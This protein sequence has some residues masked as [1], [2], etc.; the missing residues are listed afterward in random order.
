MFAKGETPMAISGPTTDHQEIRRWAKSKGA[1][2]V[3][4]LPSGIDSEPALLRLMLK[5][6]TK[7]R[8]V[9]VIGW[10]DFFAKFD[11]LGLAVV[12]DDGSTGYNEILQRDEESPYISP[13]YRL[14]TL[15]N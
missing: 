1:V 14:V 9:R 12:Y 4:V 15:G 3:E 2:P 11:A 8:Q 10:D 6:Q 13:A 7:D 5:E